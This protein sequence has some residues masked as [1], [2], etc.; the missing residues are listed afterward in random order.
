[1]Q[2]LRAVNSLRQDRQAATAAAKR[3]VIGDGDVDLERAGDRSQQ[4]LGLSQRLLEYQAEREARLDGDCRVDR[5]TAPLSGGPRLPCRDRL[6]GHP[7]GQASTL[8][9][10]H[11]VFRPVGDPVFGFGNLVAAA[12]VELV[13][14]RSHQ[15]G[16]GLRPYRQ[17]VNL[18]IRSDY[19]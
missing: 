6:L 7:Y 14:H 18:T 3:R 19:N 15:Q 10:R 5:L 16:T 2:W 13:R 12:F 8:D 9:Q 1:M 17:S 4:T 11:V